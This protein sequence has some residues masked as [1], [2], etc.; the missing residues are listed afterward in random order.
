VPIGTAWPVFHAT[1][2]QMPLG[3]VRLPSE[4]INVG[5]IPLS[6]R[7]GLPNGDTLRCLF[8]S[9]DRKVEY[10]VWFQTLKTAL[11]DEMTFFPDGSAMWYVSYLLAA[12]FTALAGVSV[13]LFIRWLIKRDASLLPLSKL[14]FGVYGAALLV[15]YLLFCVQYPYLCSFNFRYIMPVL[16][17]CAVALGSFAQKSKLAARLVVALGSVFGGL[18]LVV[19]GVYLLG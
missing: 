10:N 8:F 11:F 15:S 12:A 17:L 19:Y 13:V 18:S 16:L 9:I 14:F 6:M 3:Y 4:S 5:H 2:F 1:Q 7:F